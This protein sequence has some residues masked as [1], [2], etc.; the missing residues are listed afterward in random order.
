MWRRSPQLVSCCRIKR[1]LVIRTDRLGETLLHLPLV[2]ALKRACRDATL[3]WMVNPDL[4]ELISQAPGVDRTLGYDFDPASSWWRRAVRLAGRLRREQFDLVMISNSTKEFHLATWLAGIP[5]R[6]GYDRKWGSLLTHRV[7][8]RRALGEYHEVEYNGQFLAVLGLA[9]P[10]TTRLCLPVTPEGEHSLTQL[11]DKIGVSRTACLVVVH[12]WTSNP[13]KQWPLRQFRI[14][15]ERLMSLEA[16]RPIIVGGQEAQQQ[17]MEIFGRMEA[18]VVN[19]VGRLSLRELA[20]CL[21]RAR[22][23][24]TNDSGPMHLAAA[25]GTPVVALFGTEDAG[26]H[27]RRWG[28]W[29]NGHTVIHKPLDQITVE[30]VL[31]A[32]QRYLQP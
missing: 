18:K 29:G 20:A 23:V 21:H 3:T 5:L 32:I 2:D 6:L 13:K 17:A 30:E 26:S 7:V 12:P 22:V 15:L 9:V 25:V 16:V 4:V 24:V 10:V 11:F 27:P 1:I 14:L 28:P 31:A 8:D 19:V